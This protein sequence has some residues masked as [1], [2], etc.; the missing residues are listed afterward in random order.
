MLLKFD[1]PQLPLKVVGQFQHST[2][3]IKPSLL[4]AMY[5]TNTFPE[6]VEIQ[7]GRLS[8]NRCGVNLEFL[9]H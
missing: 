1:R 8:P 2:I 4:K 6:F 5:S 9:A 3:L 7:Y